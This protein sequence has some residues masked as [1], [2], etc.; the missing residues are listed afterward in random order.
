MDPITYGVV[1]G[2]GESFLAGKKALSEA[3]K[4]KAEKEAEV[5]QNSLD[6]FVTFYTS[7]DNRRV[8]QNQ[9]ETRSPVFLGLLNQLPAHSQAAIIGNALGDLSLTDTESQYLTAINGTN[10]TEIA[11]SLVVDMN[12]QNSLMKSPTGKG[13]W[14]LITSKAA[15]GLSVAERDLFN[16][17]PEDEQ[18]RYDQAQTLLVNYPRDSVFGS[19]LAQ[20]REPVSSGYVPLDTEF[21][22][23]IKSLLPSQS[24]K[25]DDETPVLA[26]GTLK[27]LGAARKRILPYVEAPIITTP[28]DPEGSPDP[29]FVPDQ[30]AFKDLLAIDILRSR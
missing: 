27:A 5:R 21:F 29:N 15:G 26:Q 6:T 22:N 8:A 23:S 19:I 1:M 30:R 28:E 13:V 2:L 4:E 12:V 24:G 18:Q 17:L 7:K 14:S 16:S 20:I 9:L 25:D 10:G 3:A 11:R